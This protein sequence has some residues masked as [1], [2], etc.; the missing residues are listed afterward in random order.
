MRQF[1]KS[2]HARL[3]STY[4]PVL[5]IVIAYTTPGRCADGVTAKDGKQRKNPRY[6]FQADHDPNG[7]GKFYL[8]REIAH[9]MGYGPG[10]SGARW[11]ERTSRE[12]EE[13][14]S[15]MVKSLKLRPGDVI[16]DIGAG[17]GVISVLMAEQVGPQ[18]MIL[19]VDVQQ[20][21]LDR[22]A[23]R[24]KKLGVTNVKPIK[25]TV[26]SPKLKPNS[27]DLA[28]FV[29]V[30]H[31]FKF[32]Y[33]MMLEI[34]KALK[35]GGRAVFVEY[36]MEDETVP[37]KL[38]H[39]MTQAQVRKEI[40]QLEF[41]LKWK[42]TIGVLPWQHIIIFER[43][44]GKGNSDQSTGLGSTTDRHVTDITAATALLL[45]RLSGNCRLGRPRQRR[46]TR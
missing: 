12:R 20:K 44:R 38:V 21:M 23:A 6:S 1:P 43:L 28:L 17:S 14:L 46:R 40:G 45:V 16:A 7:I 2:A 37:I 42:K 5:L 4:C 30:Y 27:I 18:G 13:K 22:L 15:L 10:G 11:L 24:C 8:G 33:E 9:V 26:K 32:P 29:D 41:A 25:G 3:L 36:R 35:P 19:A 34:S 39:K 31:E